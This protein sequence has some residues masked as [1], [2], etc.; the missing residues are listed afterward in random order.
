MTERDPKLEP[1][2]GDFVLL[3]NGARARLEE[4]GRMNNRYGSGYPYRIRYFSQH[5]RWISQEEWRGFPGHEA[6]PPPAGYASGGE[7]QR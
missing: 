6:G 5:S 3:K 4:I 7:G 2:V 1:R